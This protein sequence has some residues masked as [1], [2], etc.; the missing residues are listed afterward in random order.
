V[1][2]GWGGYHPFGNAPAVDAPVYA[3]NHDLN[4][5]AAAA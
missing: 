2:D 1:I 5:G 3:P 4:R